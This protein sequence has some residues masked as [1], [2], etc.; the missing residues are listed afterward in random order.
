M[1]QN[2]NVS[3]KVHYHLCKSEWPVSER[4][5]CELQ[6]CHALQLSQHDREI[7]RPTKY[8]V[9]VNSQL[10]PSIVGQVKQ[11]G[12]C[13]STHTRTRPFSSRTWIS[14]LPSLY[15][16]VQYKQNLWSAATWNQTQHWQNVVLLK[17]VISCREIQAPILNITHGSLNPTP[18]TSQMT[19]WLVQLF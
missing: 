8:H 17:S 11:Q 16:I 15:S 6:P 14:Q 18:P 2:F 5:S 19:P 12:H 9:N 4:K 13:L 3:C 10:K 7:G 1:F